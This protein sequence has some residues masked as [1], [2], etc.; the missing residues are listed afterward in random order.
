MNLRRTVAGLLLPA[1][2]RQYPEA[3]AAD[4]GF[5][6]RRADISAPLIAKYGIDLSPD[7]VY[8]IIYETNLGGVPLISEV[9]TN[10]GFADLTF[11]TG[12]LEAFAEAFIGEGL[13]LCPSETITLGPTPEAIHARLLTAAEALPEEGFA[14]PETALARAA[15]IQCLAADTPS[16]LSQ[17]L[18][19][20][21]E[22]LDCHRKRR[23]FCRKAALAMAAAVSKT[24]GM[25]FL[26]GIPE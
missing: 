24:I 14:P 12:A 26:N 6:G 25:E 18:R 15:F 9:R 5:F 17:A 20:A 2:K 16:S 7:T 13:L 10:G 3:A 8:N 1:L 11:S 23:V 21:E 4:L 19:L 22:A